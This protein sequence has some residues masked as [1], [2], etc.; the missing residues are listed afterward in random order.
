MTQAALR[1]SD[2]CIIVCNGAG[3]RSK[4]PPHV[5]CSQQDWADCNPPRGHQ[6]SGNL[7]LNGKGGRGNPPPSCDWR[8]TAHV[9]VTHIQDTACG[10]HAR[11]GTIKLPYP[12][13]VDQWEPPKG[14]SHNKPGK[15]HLERTHVV[16]VHRLDQPKL[17]GASVPLET[18]LVV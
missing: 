18:P 12:P 14:S 7:E 1:Y 4:A 2:V 6:P 13:L 15:H 5:L 8:R 3:D 9:E 10:N 11:E 17:F 16:R